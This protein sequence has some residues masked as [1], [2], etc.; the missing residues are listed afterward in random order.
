MNSFAM[1]DIH[2]FLQLDDYGKK[3]NIVPKSFVKE[4]FLRDE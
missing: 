2:G 1:G 3:I 4:I